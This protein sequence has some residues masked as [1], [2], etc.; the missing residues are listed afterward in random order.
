MKIVVSAGGTGGHIHPALVL[1]GELKRMN[2]I[3]LFMGKSGG[4]EAGKAAEAGLEFMGLNVRG[5]DRGNILKLLSAV[6][7]LPGAVMKALKIFSVYRPDAVI[8]VGGYASGPACIAALLKKIPLFLLEQN[9]YPGLVTRKMARRAKRVY[10]SFRESDRWLKG[11]DL[12]F[13]GNPTREGFGMNNRIRKNVKRLLVMGGSQGARSI[14]RAMI[15]ALPMID[16]LKMEIYH[17]TGPHDIEEVRTAYSKSNLRGGV[18]VVEP[19]FDNMVELM[20]SADL[21]VA[22]AGASSCAELSLCGLPA[23]LVP[24]P[25]AGGHQEFNAQAMCDNGAAEMLEDKN[26]NPESLAKRIMEIAGDS[27]RLERMSANSREMAKPDATK[28][29]S[30]DIIQTLEAA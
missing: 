16:E 26:L 5:F 7:V 21:A 10:T 3:I 4:P 30:R 20:R 29:I 19:Y 14:N 12:L 9:V 27:D 22:R 13:T 24:Y 2:N 18:C 17:Q 11:A 23:I 15:G 1:A 6:A 8:G 28:I 25:G